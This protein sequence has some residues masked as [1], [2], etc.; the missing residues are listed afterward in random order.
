MATEASLE[1]SSS[2]CTS[3]LSETKDGD[4]N[5]V[6]GQVDEEYLEQM[7]I[8]YKGTKGTREGI[9]GDLPSHTTPGW[10]LAVEWQGNGHLPQNRIHPVG[11][12][13]K[14]HS[15]GRVPGFWGHCRSCLGPS[16]P[17]HADCWGVLGVP[18]LE[19]AQ[20]GDDEDREESPASFDA[21]S[22]QMPKLPIPKE[23]LPPPPRWQIICQ[24]RRVREVRREKDPEDINFYFYQGS[25]S[26][27]PLYYC[28][29]EDCLPIIG[30]LALY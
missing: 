17:W 14:A 27:P 9:V 23:S 28:F 24:Q 4:D 29:S 15:W 1:Q 11:W 18:K 21:M 16:Q 6:Q 20:A 12:H 8:D 5:A 3:S 19:D 25:A 2:S 30:L 7:D 13:C 10:R 26:D 22:H